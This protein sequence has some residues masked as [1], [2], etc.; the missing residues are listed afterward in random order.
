LKTALAHGVFRCVTPAP[1]LRYLPFLDLPFGAKTHAAPEFA[2]QANPACRVPGG[3]RNRLLQKFCE[4]ASS[5]CMKLHQACLVVYTTP[6]HYFEHGLSQ[7]CYPYS[8]LNEYSSQ[9]T[10]A[11]DAVQI[12]API[13]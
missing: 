1:V 8:I 4:I 13:R 3:F 5:A 10:A 6:I 12:A 11:E 2:P 7:L 9:S